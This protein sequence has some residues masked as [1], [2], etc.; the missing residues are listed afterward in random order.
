MK[1]LISSTFFTDKRRIFALKIVFL[2]V[3]G[4][5][6]YLFAQSAGDGKLFIHHE[7]EVIYYCS[8]K[9]FA[10]T[11][12][13]QAE[14]CIEEMVSAIG[15]MNWYGPGYSVIYG[16]LTK[17]FGEAPARLIQFHFGFAL[18][19]LLVIL[20]FP[21]SLEKRL[22]IAI[23]L[24]L[25]EQFTLYIFTYFPETLIILL[26]VV[27]TFFLYQ[28]HEA[29]EN[30]VRNYYL[31]GFA[32]VTLLASLCRVTCIFWLAALM[33]L[34]HNRRS[35]VVMT[36]IFLLGVL[37]AMV[38]MKFFTAPAYASDMQK[39]E[40][41][42]TFDIY[43]F[44]KQ[45]FNSIARGFRELIGSGS[46]SVYIL[47]AL[48]LIAS[49]LY[50][51]TRNKLVLS[52]TLVSWCLIFVLTAF[53]TVTPYY[54]IK[55]TA[56]LVPLLLTAVLATAPPALAYSVLAS[57]LACLPGALQHTIDTI[58]ERRE[59]Y[60]KYNE[61]V[62]FRKALAQIPEY[63]QEEGT[64][65][66]WCYNEFGYGNSTESLLPF[67]TRAGK[68]IMYT[69]NIVDPSVSQDIKFKTHNRLTV[70]YILSAEALSGDSLKEVHVTEFY[71]L[72]KLR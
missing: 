30:K 55:Q 72:Y 35:F 58:E 62:T 33:G 28:A 26:A 13:V 11:G 1:Q 36:L 63:V 52:A 49:A 34:A 5:L 9:L 50:F 67:S 25:T 15:S 14:G 64:V 43:E 54:F 57:L 7:D 48:T 70:D 71:H 12:S 24:V 32:L 42:Y 46:L 51:R 18:I 29:K 6:A 68:P 41:L 38:Y 44:Q 59:A 8:G 31:A 45:T 56:M 27:L 16:L 22:S 69:S 39:I 65:I 21:T 4:A 37:A 53:Y 23:A 47:L 20:T 10:E 2:I 66:L 60:V 19:A 40:L 17:V 61:Y 3:I